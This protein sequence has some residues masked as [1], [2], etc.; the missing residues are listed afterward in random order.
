[1]K[2]RAIRTGLTFVGVAM[3][4]IGI[5][6]AFFVDSIA[7]SGLVLVALGAALAIAF[8]TNRRFADVRRL[9]LEGSAPWKQPAPPPS[10]PDD[11]ADDGVVEQLFVPTGESIRGTDSTLATGRFGL[12]RSGM[13]IVEN[14][15]TGEKIYRLE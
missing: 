13:E 1:M 9:S 11:D 12:H 5:K 15:E 4:A 14:H 3:I 6:A 2:R 10:A 8:G 7:L